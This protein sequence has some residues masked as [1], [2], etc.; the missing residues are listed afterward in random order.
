[1]P[2]LSW[3]GHAH[4]TMTDIAPVVQARPVDAV[5]ERISG[6]LRGGDASPETHGTEHPATVGEHLARFEPRARMEDLSGQPCGALEPLDD[7]PAARGTD[8]V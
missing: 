5:G 7:I 6:T 2:G 1:M 3:L 8:W 4:G